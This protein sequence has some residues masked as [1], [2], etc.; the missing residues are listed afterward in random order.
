MLSWSILAACPTT[1]L[2]VSGQAQCYGSISNVISR[3][4]HAVGGSKSGCCP[5]GNSRLC[6]Q[7]PESCESDFWAFQSRVMRCSLPQ[8]CPKAERRV[9]VHVIRTEIPVELVDE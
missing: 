7:M 2:R 4:D 3:G 1:G 6:S 5:L 8:R 9:Q